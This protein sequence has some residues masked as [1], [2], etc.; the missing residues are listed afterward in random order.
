MQ[1]KK[2][3]PQ[4][5]TV[6]EEET[7]SSQEIL[8]CQK[9]DETFTTEP[10]LK[11]HTKNVHSSKVPVK[12]ILCAFTSQS[13]TQFLLHMEGHNSSNKNPREKAQNN[14]ALCKYFLQG[15]CNFGVHCWNSHGVNGTQCKFRSRCNAWPACNFSHYEV[16]ASCQDCKIRKRPLE[17][18]PSPFL[19]KAKNTLP[20]DL[21]CQSSF[22]KLPTIS[23][24][25][26]S[27]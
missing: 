4:N 7:E 6:R 13:T 12:C 9:C 23:R 1:K 25:R 22:P 15:R 27:I 2:N 10:H 21:N 18:P 20:P 17:H 26:K 24:K 19:V 3:D 14:G 16:C 8:S 11:T 5:K